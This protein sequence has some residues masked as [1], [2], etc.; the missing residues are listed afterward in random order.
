MMRPFA[1]L[2]FKYYV[3][4]FPTFSTIAPFI[5]PLITSKSQFYY[6]NPPCTNNNINYI[7][8]FSLNKHLF[9]DIT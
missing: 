4:L 8:I 9:F 5:I 6:I 7:D 1:K 2:I 3:Y